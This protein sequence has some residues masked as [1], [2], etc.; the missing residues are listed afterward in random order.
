VECCLLVF[1]VFSL[2]F[3]VWWHAL[4]SPHFTTNSCLS[5]AVFSLSHYYKNCHD[6]YDDF[7][8]CTCLKVTVL[9]PPSS[10]RQRISPCNIY[11]L[12]LLHTLFSSALGYFLW[13]EHHELEM[14]PSSDDGFIK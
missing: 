7:G 11:N 14:I 10:S 12:I 4:L 13:I 1:S 2:Q 3:Q 9:R 6:A 5:V 8:L